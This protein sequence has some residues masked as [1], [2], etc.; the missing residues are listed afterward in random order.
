MSWKPW[1]FWSIALSLLLSCTSG[2]HLSRAQKQQAAFIMGEKNRYQKR[3]D[4][5][6][7]YDPYPSGQGTIIQPEDSGR[8]YLILFQDGDF[9]QSSP[10]NYSE[11]QWK[12]DEEK[13]RLAL[14][15]RMQNNRLVPSDKRDTLYRYELRYHSADSLVLAVQ[16][17]HGL[18]EYRYRKAQ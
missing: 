16:G 15:Y 14:I 17:R 5:Q 18:V 6:Q 4:L 2:W 1:L 12:L 3:W 10:Q 8:T 7:M 13:Q 11:G 9:L